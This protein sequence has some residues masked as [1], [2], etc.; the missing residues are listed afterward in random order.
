MDEK[1][2]ETGRKA[3]SKPG[4]YKSCTARDRTSGGALHAVHPGPSAVD[5]RWG[6]EIHSNK[7]RFFLKP[8]RSIQPLIIFNTLQELHYTVH[9]WP[10]NR[11]P[12]SRNR[13]TQLFV[14]LG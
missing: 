12:N 6:S 11:L 7:R 13:R 8:H 4:K 10:S 14:L 2:V 9:P 1:V 5:N 3:A